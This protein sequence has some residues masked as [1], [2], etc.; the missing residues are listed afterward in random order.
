MNHEQIIALLDHEDFHIRSTALQVIEK[1][2]LFDF[3]TT[4]KIVKTIDQHGFL[5]ASLHCHLCKKSPLDLGAAQC[6]LEY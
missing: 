3:S 5:E 6:L 1:R 4:K 2:Q